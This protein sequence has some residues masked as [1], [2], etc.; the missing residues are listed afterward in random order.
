M[1]YAQEQTASDYEVLETAIKLIESPDRWCQHVYHRDEHG[2][3]CIQEV[4]VSHCMVGALWA[5]HCH[6]AQFDRI[7]GAVLCGEF[8]ATNAYYPSLS[9]FNDNHTHEEVML[10]MKRGLEYLASKK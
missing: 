6:G 5:A 3:P 9:C 8:T 7:S 2:K 1:V 4:A 10:A